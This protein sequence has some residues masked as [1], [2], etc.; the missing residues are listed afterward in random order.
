MANWVIEVP[1]ADIWDV[2]MPFPDKR[3]AIVLRLLKSQWI[4]NS[5]WPDEV[6]DLIHALGWTQ[7]VSEFDTVFYQLCDYADHD[8]VWI[9][10]F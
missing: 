1:L 6:E 10:T 9:A 5:F 8:G 4:P 2:E 3:N 7:S